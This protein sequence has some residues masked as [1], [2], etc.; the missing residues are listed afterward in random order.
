MRIVVPY[1]P[2]DPKTRLSPVLSADERVA[3]SR[4]M[5]ADVLE[6]ISA[7]GHA[8]EVL[9]TASLPA[10][11]VPVHV[12][13]RS[14]SDA[15]NAII[16]PP[17]AVVMADL[18]LLTPD[19]LRAAVDSQAD[20]VIGPGRGGGT[21]LLIVR[22]D[23]FA[24]DYHGNSLADHRRIA[25]AAGLSLAEIDS[26]RIATDVDEPADLVEVLLHGRGH[27]RDWLADRGFV[28]TETDGRV[29]VERE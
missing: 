10:I 1:T 11:E 17:T 6:A 29:A 9:A 13:E 19:A 8:P 28:L 15:V 24:V 23:G 14:L 16:T 27:A 4:V 12:D 20:V 22:A 3:F 5:L 21:N 2:I 25:A 7:L 18:A 26:F